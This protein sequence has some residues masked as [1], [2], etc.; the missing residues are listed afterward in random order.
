MRLIVADVQR[1]D[2]QDTQATRFLERIL[3][4]DRAG[5]YQLAKACFEERGVTFLHEE[6]V[7]PA[8]Y[9]VGELWHADRITVADEHL[10]SAT[11]AAA[12]AALY[13]FFP[14]PA[15]RAP[16]VVVA[17]PQ[18]EHHGFGARMLADAIALDGWDDYYFGADVPHGMLARKVIDFAPAAVALSVTLTANLDAAREAV[19]HVRAAGPAR[20][21]LG[22]RAVVKAPGLAASVGADAIAGSSVEGVEVLRGWR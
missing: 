9:Q 17:C 8:L 11:A 3:A 6:V 13:P 10:A 5:A 14:W 2:V 4:G 19:R 15:K 16:R 18:G 21:L 22:G 7:S 12:V 1:G 20:I